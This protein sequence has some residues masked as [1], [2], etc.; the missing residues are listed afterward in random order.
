MNT[1]PS[2]PDSENSDSGN[3]DSIFEF[4]TQWGSPYSFEETPPTSDDELSTISDDD[5]DDE[6]IEKP[7]SLHEQLH[8]PLGE[9]H[10]ALIC[11]TSWFIILTF[12]CR[13]DSTNV[14]P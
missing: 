2:D 1:L 10:Y 8:L 14:P 7:G 12:R 6:I 9:G 5:D 11:M 3:S 13:G 4:G